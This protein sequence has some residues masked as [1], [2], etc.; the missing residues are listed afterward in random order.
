VSL[1]ACG[2]GQRPHGVRPEENNSSGHV[3]Y[4]R[5]QRI[6]VIRKQ[7]HNQLITHPYLEDL[8]QRV[9]NA[10]YVSSWIIRIEKSVVTNDLDA[11][12][13]I[14]QYSPVDIKQPEI[15]IFTYQ[16]RN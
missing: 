15:K 4:I 13:L 12:P 6:H 14:Q 3:L 7:L 8:G 16:Q 1:K 5:E 11:A 10:S 2:H 9:D